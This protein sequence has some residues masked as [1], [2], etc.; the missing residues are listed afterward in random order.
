[1]NPA[2]SPIKPPKQPFVQVIA[3]EAQ[4][5]PVNGLRFLI[6][7]VLG[8]NIHLGMDLNQ[9]LEHASP[10]TRAVLDLLFAQHQ[11]GPLHELPLSTNRRSSASVVGLPINFIIDR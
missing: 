2:C 4:M 5:I 9:C 7:Q 10:F 8:D 3:D 1:M 11:K 6:E